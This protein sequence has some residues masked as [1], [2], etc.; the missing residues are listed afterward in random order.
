MLK[1]KTESREVNGSQ[2]PEAEKKLLFCGLS[3]FIVMF[4]FESGGRF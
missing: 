1:E 2:S 4:S 3:Y